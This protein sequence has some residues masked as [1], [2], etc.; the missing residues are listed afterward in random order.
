MR[1]DMKK[2]IL[3]YS[4]YLLF[5]ALLLLLLVY[6]RFPHEKTRKWIITS[7]E[8]NFSYNLTIKDIRLVF[9]SGLHLTDVK[10]TTDVKN[11]NVP[12][13][14][15]KGVRARLQ[16]LPLLVGHLDFKYTIYAYDGTIRGKVK[17]RHGTKTR[18]ASIASSINDVNLLKSLPL[19]KNLG[20]YPSGKV[21]GKLKVVVEDFNTPV[22]RGDTILTVENGKIKG[23]NIK[24]IRVR[25]VSYNGI[26]CAFELVRDKM[27][28][29]ELSLRGEDIEFSVAGEI[30]V[31]KEIGES[32]LRLRLKF[33]PTKGFEK[34]YRLVFRSFKRLKDKKGYFSFPVRGTL[35][36][37]KITVP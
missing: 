1:I 20:F 22:L 3:T 19:D 34:K 5:G 6:M 27:D 12:I 37:P 16:V 29:K 14:Q 23:I 4:G 11:K 21:D 13:F 9:P 26:D 18:T 28:L 15:A 10:I 25:D 24:G 30:L 35:E 17:I 8:N 32:S 2:R 7:F 36:S 33:K 31:G